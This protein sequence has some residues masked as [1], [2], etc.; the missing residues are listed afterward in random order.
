MAESLPQ[1]MRRI[2]I[3]VKIFCLQCRLGDEC[4][5]FP[6][7]KTVDFISGTYEVATAEMSCDC[8]LPKQTSF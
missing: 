1:F 2:K 4:G 5:A 3:K 6:N 8:E 7:L